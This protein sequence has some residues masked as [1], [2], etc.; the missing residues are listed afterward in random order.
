MAPAYRGKRITVTVT[1]TKTGYL[2]VART[3]AATAAVAAGSLTTTPTPTI[4]GTAK[5]GYTLTAHAGT[6][7]PSPVTLHYQWKAD[8]AAISGATAGSYKVAPAYRASGS[9]SP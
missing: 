9:P 6:W 2:T 5:V 4:T 7:G 1:G 3:S 8:G